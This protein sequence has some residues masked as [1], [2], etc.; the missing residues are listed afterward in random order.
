MSN[1][2]QPQN[3]DAFSVVANLAGPELLDELHH[4][5]RSVNPVEFALFSGAMR[6]TES[7]RY[8]DMVESV[9]E[10]RPGIDQPTQINIPATLAAERPQ[11]NRIRTDVDIPKLLIVADMPERLAATTGS[12]SLRTLG[13]YSVALSLVMA[14]RAR[15]R[16][17]MVLTD[18]SGAE[19]VF[20]D[21]A[22]ESYL[23]MDA[24]DNPKKLESSAA[25]SP[26]AT[27]LSMVESEAFGHRD[28]ALVVSDFM[29]GHN[30]DGTMDWQEPLSRLSGSLDDRLLTVRLQSPAQMDLPITQ[31]QLPIELVTAIREAYQDKALRKAQRI[32]IALAHLRHV[33]VDAGNYSV[34]PIVQIN[35]FLVG[36]E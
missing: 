16:A 8:G 20:N 6:S 13:R 19:E 9:G 21:S 24:I 5:L 18:T 1:H 36:T 3:Q 31:T 10:F 11:A 14:Q 23:A 25:M 4:G 15:A 2:N 26:L 12:E 28:V 17:E 27:A 33:S 34:H 7:T 22:S 32:S 35:D 30:E 29:D